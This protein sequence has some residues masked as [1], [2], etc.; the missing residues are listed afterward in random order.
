MRRQGGGLYLFNVKPEVMGTLQRGGQADAI[1]ADHVFAMKTEPI[2]AL[3]PRLDAA[4]C[5]R[6]E[7]RIF[8]QCQQWLPDGRPR[9]PA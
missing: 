8:R 9:L 1:G 5:Q 4:Q 2:D 6:C 7:R 3:Y